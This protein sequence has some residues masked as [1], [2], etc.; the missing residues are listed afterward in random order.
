M[1]EAILA[2]IVSRPIKE[3]VAVAISRLNDCRYCVDA[4]T[5]ML[6]A[7]SSHQAASAVQRGQAASIKDSTIGDA[8]EWAAASRSPGHPLLRHPPFALQAAP[9]MIGVAVWVHYINRMVAPLLGDRLLWIGTDQGALRSLSERMAGWFFAPVVNRARPPGFSLQLLPPAELPEDLAW[10]RSSAHVAH[11][12]AAFASAVERGGAVSLTPDA[13]A[14]VLRAVA[15]WNGEDP[16]AESLHCWS[17]EAPDAVRAEV[18][19]GLFAAL[20][21][22]RVDEAVISAFR[23]RRPADADLI[24]ALAWG[25]FTAARRIG[26]WLAQTEKTGTGYGVPGSQGIP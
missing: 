16:G 21:P 14:L 23:R 13:R 19:L 26:S 3:S 24:G 6:R 9:E 2:G 12:F 7:A 15:E 18:R 17:A 1:R 4:H 8:A 25:S 20:A 5:V 11:A 10:A 22:W